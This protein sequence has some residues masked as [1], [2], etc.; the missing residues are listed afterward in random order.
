M[1]DSRPV[2]NEHIK[3]YIRQRPAISTE[4]LDLSASSASAIKSYSD[5]GS[6]SYFQNASKKQ[7]DFRFEGFL[8]SS[9]LQEEAYDRV[10]RPIVDSA[11]Q[12]YSG[13][14]K[15]SMKSTLGGNRLTGCVL[16]VFC[17]F[18]YNICL[19][20]DKL[21]KDVYNAWIWRQLGYHATVSSSSIWYLVIVYFIFFVHFSIY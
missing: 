10:A 16:S 14:V 2:I 15:V 4:S 9:I 12:G 7:I 5:D 6:C 13:F 1:P 18:Q 21:R 3:V 20:S 8:G 17:L 19:W 11:L